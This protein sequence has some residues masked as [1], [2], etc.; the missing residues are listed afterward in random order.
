MAIIVNHRE[1][2]ATSA[3]TERQLRIRNRVNSDV[4]TKKSARAV[5]IRN[6]NKRL[7]CHIV[8]ML[9]FE[10]ERS[11]LMLHRDLQSSSISSNVRPRNGRGEGEGNR[12]TDAAGDA[13]ENEGR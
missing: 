6:R 12:T 4:L 3:D 5:G 2:V 9:A 1:S 10:N 7:A 13:M 11:R 8:K